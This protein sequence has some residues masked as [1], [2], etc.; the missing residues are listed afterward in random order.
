MKGSAER[1]GDDGEGRLRH[2]AGEGACGYAHP[3][4]RAAL[5]APPRSVRATALRAPCPFCHRPAVSTLAAQAARSAGAAAVAAPEKVILRPCHWRV[6]KAWLGRQEDNEARGFAA[7]LYAEKSG[8]RVA[9]ADRTMAR[10]LEVSTASDDVIKTACL[11]SKWPEDRVRRDMI[12]ARQPTGDKQRKGKFGEVLHAAILEEFSGMLIVVK[13]H[14]YNPAP[15]ASPHG[16]DLIAL[17]TPPG[18][19][20]ADEY[21]VYVETKLRTAADPNVLRSSYESLAKATRPDI[22]AHLG[23]ELERLHESDA[24][25]FNRIAVAL[26]EGQQPRLR[27]GV[28]V[29]SLQWSDAPLDLLAKHV[30]KDTKG[31]LD[32]DIVRIVDLEDLIDKS[33][34]GVGSIV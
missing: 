8:W 29:E 2:G 3:A 18:G 14:R 15:N 16:V 30:D 28:V 26:F 22:P 7:F 23:A 20:G 11:I 13:K 12:T 10:L 17:Q 4:D 21:I 31:R 24:E 5:S 6:L 27:I 33:Y 25:M 32:V 9:G 1:R 34:A 19:T